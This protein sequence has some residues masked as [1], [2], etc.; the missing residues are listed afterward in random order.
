MFEVI[1][2]QGGYGIDIPQKNDDQ[3]WSALSLNALISVVY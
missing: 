3:F 2:K 1:L